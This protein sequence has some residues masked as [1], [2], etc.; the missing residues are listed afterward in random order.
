[1]ALQGSLAVCRAVGNGKVSLETWEHEGCCLECRNF[2][3]KTG[4]DAK[5]GLFV[6]NSLKTPTRCLQDALP[7]KLAETR[8]FNSNILPVVVLITFLA[9]SVSALA[10]AQVITRGRLGCKCI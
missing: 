3:L 5:F 6:F 8:L 9:G 10:K 2:N 1:M 7:V 4:D